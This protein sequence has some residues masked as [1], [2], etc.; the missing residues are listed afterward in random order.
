[1]QNSCGAAE[2]VAAKGKAIKDLG[3]VAVEILPTKLKGMFAADDGEVAFEIK[4]LSGAR[5]EEERLPKS[6]RGGKSNSRIRHRRQVDRRT[7]T[8]L[9]SV[10][11]V[12][13][14]QL[15]IA[16]R[17]GQVEIQHLD[18][19]WAFDAIGGRAVPGCSERKPKCPDPSV[20]VL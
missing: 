10:G 11:D 18:I 1:M 16:Q 20:T 15:P 2:D 14:V 7:W 13:L 4:A 17:R 12:S 9:V 6:E 3:V 8:S 5:S 19:S